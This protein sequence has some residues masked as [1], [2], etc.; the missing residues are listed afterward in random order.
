MAKSEEPDSMPLLSVS[1]GGEQ[2]AGMVGDL[3]DFV[4]TTHR[5]PR[6]AAGRNRT[7]D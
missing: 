7:L 6:L 4:G 1:V 2:E 3:V 5:L